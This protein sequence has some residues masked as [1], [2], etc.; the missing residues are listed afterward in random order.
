MRH[1]SSLL[2]TIKLIKYRNVIVSIIGKCDCVLNRE[3]S[4]QEHGKGA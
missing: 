4:V 1:I 2:E 3:S